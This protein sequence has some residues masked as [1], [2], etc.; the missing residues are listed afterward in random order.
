M[1]KENRAPKEIVVVIGP[2]S[3][4]LAIA[5]RVGTGRTLL[6]AAHDE[7]ASEAAADQLRGEGY[8]VAVQTTDISDPAQVEALAATAA[9][10]G[11]VTQ[12]I[13]AAGVSP[14]QATVERLLHVDLLGT[15]YVLDAFA[16]VIAPGGAGIVVASMAGHRESPYAPEIEHALAT[17]ETSQLLALPFL[18]PDQLGSSVHAYAM[19][20]RA[21]SLRVQTA[22]AAWG[23]RGARVNAV[24]PGVIITP[25]ALDELSGPRRE[26]FDKV[27]EVSAA[28]RFGASEEVA[29]AAAFLLG[30]EAGFIT[31]ADLLMDGGVTAALRAGE[32]STP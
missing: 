27:R 19:S 11:A 12:V 24:S 16:R 15:A 31:G 28:K 20:K 26:W 2:G 18:Q 25:L 7:K 17:T 21:N 13:Q 23:K 29:A 32:L 6:L 4:G 9:E 8:E 3:I 22:A 14:T 1:S 10:M 5:R 30:R